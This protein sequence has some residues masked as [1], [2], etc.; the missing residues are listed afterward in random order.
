MNLGR[1]MVIT[2][3]FAILMPSDRMVTRYSPRHKP[4]SC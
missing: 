4:K 3:F 2:G 1:S